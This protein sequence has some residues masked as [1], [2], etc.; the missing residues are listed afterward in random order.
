MSFSMA[1]NPHSTSSVYTITDLSSALLSDPVQRY[2]AFAINCNS[3]RA[4]RSDLEH[5][6][7]WGGEIPCSPDLLARYIAEHGDR[8]KVS[9]LVRRLSSLAKA[10]RLAN[11]PDPTKSELVKT[12]LRGIKRAHGSRQ[13]QAKPLTREMLDTVCSGLGRSLHDIR[14][15]ALFLV[16]FASG[17]RRSEL[18]SLQVEQVTLTAAGAELLLLRSKNDGDGKGRVIKLAR[19]G[20]SLCPVQA[21][22]DWLEYGALVSGPL[23][24]PIDRWGRVLDRALSGEAVG[25]LLRRRLSAMGWIVTALP[26][27]ASALASFPPRSSR[28][29]RCGGSGI[30]RDTHPTSRPIAIFDVL[31]LR[32]M[33]CELDPV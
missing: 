26:D 20:G 11:L 27:I 31:S 6:R 28:E 32:S 25:E 22:Q 18:C 9:T 23:F 3:A 19:T 2:L 1:D 33:F 12:V 17:M 7:A 29:R 15:R 10:H 5:F 13:E 30:R 21:L 14:D 8:L 16:G 24:R 4:Y